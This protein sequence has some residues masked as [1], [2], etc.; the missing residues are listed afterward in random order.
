MYEWT[1]AAQVDEEEL[2]LRSANSD[3]ED[4]L[5]FVEGTG[6][7]VSCRERVSSRSESGENTLCR[8]RVRAFF[9]RPVVECWLPIRPILSNGWLSVQTTKKLLDG[10]VWR[11]N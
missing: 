7:N 2:E 11:W 10:T 1:V 5:L 4:W 8:S 3:S 6:L 9:L